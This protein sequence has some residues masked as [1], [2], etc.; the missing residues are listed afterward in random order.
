MKGVFPMS[1]HKNSVD[2][3]ETEWYLPK[4]R[5]IIPM[6]GFRLSKNSDR[7]RRNKI[8]HTVRYNSN[9]RGVLAGCASRTETW[10]SPVIIAS[11][12]NLHRLGF[13]HSVEIYNEGEEL[14]GGLYGVALGTAFF[15]ESMFHYQPEADKFAL[16]Y[17]HQ[18]LKERGFTLW[19]TQFYT[20]HLGTMGAVAISN[21]D[22]Q[23]LL[24][25][26]LDRRASFA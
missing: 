7:L 11:Y 15:G 12:V 18:R 24:M 4:V 10:I 6:D 19:D 13:A 16:Y 26:A 25:Q 21:A 8:P 1:P 22:Y 20:D 17:C 23:D 14:V 5:G 3:E 9:F 2:P